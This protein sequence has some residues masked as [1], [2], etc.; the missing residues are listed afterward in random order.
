MYVL[1]M[2]K[3]RFNLPSVGNGLKSQVSS[4]NSKQTH[5]TIF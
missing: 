3:E 5:L 2:K 4:K 1:S